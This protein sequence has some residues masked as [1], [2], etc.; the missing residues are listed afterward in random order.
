ME[1]KQIYNIVNDITSEILGEKGIVTEDL[2][3]IVTVGEELFN[4]NK[5]DNYVRSLVDRI[6]R[7]IFVDRVYRGR[8]PRVLMDD[9][10][11]G[12][13]LEKIQADIPEATENESWELED[14]TSYDPNI[15][16]KPSVSVKFFNHKVTFEIPL[17]YTE[18]QVRESF[19]NPQ[20]LN[21]FLSMIYNSVYKSMTIKT[22]ALIMR[23]ITNMIAETF[24]DFD[25]AGT[26]TGKSGVRAI[27][28]L[29][30]YQQET[31]D[32]TVTATNY[33]SSPE[34]IR[35]AT[36][37]MA[38]YIDRLAVIS[39]LF[40]IGGKQRFTPR[41]LLHVVLLND[42]AK[43]SEVYLQSDTFHNELVALPNYESVAYWQGSG[44]SYALS[45]ITNINVKTASGH[46]VNAKG[47]IGVMFDRDA[48]GVTQQNPRVTSNYN[49]KA[50]FF[51]EWHKW[52]ASYFNDFNE[53]CVVFYVA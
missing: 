8:A 51:N 16:T 41:D 27:N 22:D 35:F 2:S 10:E 40:N 9:W 5:V 39:E 15:F 36:Y 14:G 49:P 6:G 26:Y 13:V 23:T 44:T 29:Y 20:Q 38:L 25:N 32:E 19:A 37:K 21:S 18:L 17:S 24:Y 50:E 31:D 43:A 7:V 1:V 45:D 47:V 33:M 3:N 34:F 11:Y 4:A 48:L 46:I 52:D 28:L 30:L 53:N 12:S 42:F